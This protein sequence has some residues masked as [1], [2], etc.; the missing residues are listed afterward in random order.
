[1]PP[2][3]SIVPQRRAGMRGCTAAAN[4]GLANDAAVISVA[5]QPG[6]IELTR[7]RW[8]ASSTA[9]ARTYAVTAPFDA[10]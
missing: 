3:S 2:K 9:S 6:R 5:I 1:M 4:F 10:P 7:I 8:R